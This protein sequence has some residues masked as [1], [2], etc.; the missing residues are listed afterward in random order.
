MNSRVIERWRR[1]ADM[2][3]YKVRLLHGVVA[4]TIVLALIGALFVWQSA[5]LDLGDFALPGPGFF[6]LALAILVVAFSIA[7][8]FRQQRADS[9]E[10]FELGHRDV[11]I[12]FAA[13]L[14]VPL[15]FDAL[16]A[17]ITLGAFGAAVLILIARA[18]PLISVAA[19]A[20]GMAA[21]YY[22]FQV[23]LG[24]QMPTGPF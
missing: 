12:V 21:S 18:S 11:L 16:G 2:W 10:T 14:M 8:A 20:I 6:P 9:N 17:Y 24:L 15:L 7:I 19:C 3:P 5:L 4:S 22:F 1:F 13:G 23:L